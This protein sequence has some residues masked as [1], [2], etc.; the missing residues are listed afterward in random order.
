MIPGITDRTRLPRI[1]KIRLGEKRQTKAGK[2]YP[3]ALDHFSFEDV[4]EVGQ[5]YPGECRELFPMVLPSDDED[6][7]FP[8]ARKAYGRS[9]LFCACSDGAT[10]HR[11]WVGEKDAHGAAYARQHGLRLTEGELYDLPCA[12]LACPYSEQNLCKPLGR[13]LFMLPEVP[14]FG[15]YEIATTSVNSMQ[16]ILSVTRAVRSVVGR[17]S[18]IPFALRLVPI[19]VQPDGKAKTVHVL[20][21]EVRGSLRELLRLGERVRSHGVGG[22]LLPAPAED[23]PDDLYP[24]AGAALDAAVGSPAKPPAPQVPVPAAPAGR[25]APPRRPAAEPQ[26]PEPEEVRPAAGMPAA[27]LGARP[28]PR[29][30]AVQ[31]ELQPQ[32][33]EHGS[34]IE[35]LL[36]TAPEPLPA[37]PRLTTEE[38]DANARYLFPEGEDKPASAHPAARPAAA[39]APAARWAAAPP[40]AG[41]TA[42]ERRNRAI[43][44]WDA[45]A[46]GNGDLAAAVAREAGFDLAEVAAAPVEKLEMLARALA[47]SVRMQTTARP[48]ADRRP[49]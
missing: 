42:G 18:G 44:A 25:A 31:A 5:V 12:G 16:G 17:V 15:C 36:N 29:R 30:Q 2:D 7:F 35:D 34:D 43:A 48:A 41:M 8:T 33:A 10:A 9:G 6:V 23:V 4:P 26:F 39:P 37:A 20:Q 45:A 27:R 14:R 19:Q 11:V 40:P 1:G 49:S 32:P 28:A 22:G 3:A 46:K 47:G 38:F 24:D 21:L 13:L